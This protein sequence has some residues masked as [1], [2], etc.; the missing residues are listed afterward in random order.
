MTF[1]QFL[2]EKYP[3]Y[4]ERD[5]YNF[6]VPLKQVIKDVEEWINRNEPKNTLIGVY[7]S[8][9]TEKCGGCGHK[10]CNCHD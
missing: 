7:T 3:L 8:T 6:H 4:G 1:E 10:E 9:C 2:I 5:M